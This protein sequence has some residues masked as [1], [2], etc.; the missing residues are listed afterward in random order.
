MELRINELLRE[1]GLKISDLADKIGVDQSNLKRSLAN[2]PKLSTLQDVAKALHVHVHELF[3]PN[4]PT[5]PSGVVVVNGRTYGLVENPSVVQI[6]SYNNF[7]ALRKEVKGFVN[8]RVKEGKT[9]AFCALVCGYQLVSLVYDCVAKKFILTLYYGDSE[10]KTFFFDL[11]E[12]AEWKD[13]NDKDPI[14]NLEDV[15]GQI[16]CDIENVVSFEFGDY[17]TPADREEDELQG[18]GK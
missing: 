14:W 5:T 10:S 8:S 6:P 13:G 12:F 9:G 11:M 16:T 4:L 15:A 7:S 18:E 17:T 2:N 3:T 1:Q